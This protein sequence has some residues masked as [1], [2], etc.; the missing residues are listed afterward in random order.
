VYNKF[1]MQRDIV[2]TGAIFGMAIIAL[3]GGAAK[4]P[5]PQTTG[6]IHAGATLEEAE[7]AKEVFERAASNK[8]TPQPRDQATN[9]STHPQKNE[10]AA[11]E[12]TTKAAPVVKSMKPTPAT[13]L[14]PGQAPEKANEPSV[15]A[16]EGKHIPAVPIQ[17][18]APVKPVNPVEPEKKPLDKMSEA[19]IKEK[20]AEYRTWVHEGEIDIELEM[21]RLS[22]VEVARLV[23][24]YV[25][26]T[27]S[28][29]MQLDRDG[30]VSRLPQI[31]EARLI[32]DLIYESQWPDG[33]R[34]KAD[35][36]FGGGIVD[37]N[38]AIVL[39]KMAELHLYRV[40]VEGLNGKHPQPG[41]MVLIGI[42]PQDND[43]V[44][45]VVEVTAANNKKRS[46][47]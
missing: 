10:P 18:S 32:A 1:N 40:L 13:P 39:N 35:A 25:M 9:R 7:P 43:L 28:T 36:W 15:S 23:D 17:R 19:E 6:P 4:T 38:V 30:K 27:D 41:S 47:Q 34:A 21:S 31:P 29:R 16:Q 12:Q 33:T 8:P 11:P 24:F 14:M 20:L 37:V 26:R 42:E 3:A 44:F 22:A 46:T 2:T 45:Q 5:P